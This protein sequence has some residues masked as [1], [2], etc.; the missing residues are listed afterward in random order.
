MVFM[1]LW[2]HNPL[3]WPKPPYVMWSLVAI[4]FGVFFYQMG[5]DKIDQADRFAGLIP[6]ALTS[7]GLPGMLWP[8][9]TLITSMF[10]HANFMHVFGNMLFLFVF[11][12]DI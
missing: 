4:N 3:K 5:A 1:P 6:V 12:D 11:G 8:P 9:L 10:L 7:G 2:D